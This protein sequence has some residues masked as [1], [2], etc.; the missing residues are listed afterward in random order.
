MLVENSRP[1]K[2][3]YQLFL[4]K[5]QHCRSK[6]GR[7]KSYVIACL[8]SDPRLRSNPES[9]NLNLALA[10]RQTKILSPGVVSVIL[11][12]RN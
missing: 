12:L 10:R 5:D 9:L 2:K 7:E 11:K 1:C 4:F 8:R 3:S 6:V